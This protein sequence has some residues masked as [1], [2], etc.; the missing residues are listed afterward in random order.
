[1]TVHLRFLLIACTLQ[2]AQS[3]SVAADGVKGW[4]EEDC[5]GAAI[6]LD[7]FKG[8]PKANTSSCGSIAALRSPFTCLK[9]LAGWTCMASVVLVS[10]NA[11]MPLRQRSG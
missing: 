9:E 8:A 7:K 5:S 4:F 1:M 2:A 11:R 3:I 10:A 6:H